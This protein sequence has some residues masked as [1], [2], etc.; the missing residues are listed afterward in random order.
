MPLR[1]PILRDQVKTSSTSENLITEIMQI[2]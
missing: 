1:L 2:M